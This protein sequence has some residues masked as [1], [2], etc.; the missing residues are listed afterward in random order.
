MN[1]VPVMELE[2]GS[3]NCSTGVEVVDVPSALEDMELIASINLDGS[4]PSS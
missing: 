1:N 4:V 3:G 2:I